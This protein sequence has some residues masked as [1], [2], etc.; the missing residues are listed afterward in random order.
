TRCFCHVADVVRALIDLMLL[1]EGAYGEVFNIG[2]QE[3]ISMVDL[4]NR[5]REMTGSGS[6]IQV[7]PYDEAYEAGFEDM[8]RRYPEISKIGAAVGWSPTRSLDEILGDVI[9][10]HQSEAAVV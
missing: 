10:F 5:V 7:I 1:G 8:P 4:A 3:E 9:S 2:A 6:E